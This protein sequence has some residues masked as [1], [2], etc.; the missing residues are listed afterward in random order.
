M[1]EMVSGIFAGTVCGAVTA[2][3]GYAKSV[4]VEKFNPKKAL[5]TVVVGAVIGGV[6][7]YYGW[8]YSRAEEWATNVGLIT[9]VEY[10]KK[11]ILRRVMRNERK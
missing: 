1:M 2:L 7:G 11:A 5:Q 9:L 4:T 3:L 10:L 8:S 6:S